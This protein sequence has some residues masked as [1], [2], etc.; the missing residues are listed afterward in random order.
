MKLSNS[1]TSADEF[2]KMSAELDKHISVLTSKV[3]AI[4]KK[5][6]DNVVKFRDIVRQ[7]IE[8]DMQDRVGDTVKKELTS[9][10][11]EVQQT[12][13]ESKEF[14]K[15]IREEQAELE[16]I[17]SRRCNVI[18]YRIPES[19]EVLADDRNKQDVSVCEHFFNA[20]NVGFDKDDIRR[21]QR[22]GRRNENSPRPVLVQFG[23]RYIK[24]LIIESLYKI[25]SMNTRFCNITVAH[26]LT[27]KQRKECKALVEEAKA[28]TDQETGDFIYRVRGPP[29]LLQ[30]V[31]LRKTH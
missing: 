27:R 17:E 5:K 18:L 31:R 13:N 20:F 25:K 2:N 19:D 24:N 28:K 15:S 6:M 8:E 12:I 3:E 16:D 9:Q 10:V 21:V 22:H 23:N 14:A 26:D 11:G 30:V 1:V 29:G 7:Q 4:G